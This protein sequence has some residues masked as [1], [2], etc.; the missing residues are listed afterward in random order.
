MCI[1]PVPKVCTLVAYYPEKILSPATGFPPNVN[2]LAHLA[3]SQGMAPRFR[4]YSYPDTVPGFAETDL[5]CYDKVSANLAW[6]RTLAA[7]RKGFNIEVDLE[8]IW[9]EQ[10]RGKHQNIG[11]W[12]PEQVE[13]SQLSSSLRMS[14]LQWQL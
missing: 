8:S 9:E 4:S 1:E 6:S 13:N 12:R 14:M 5:T 2:V 3:G 7:V 11:Y 10:L